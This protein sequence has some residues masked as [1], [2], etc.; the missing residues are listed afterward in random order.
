MSK[1]LIIGN[2]NS[3]WPIDHDDGSSYWADSYNFLA[4]GGYK[5]LFG[6]S[7]KALEN[8][9]VYPDKYVSAHVCMETIGQQLGTGE[10]VY[11]FYLPCIYNT[12]KFLVKNRQSRN[13]K[14]PKGL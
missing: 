3:V 9:Y 2:Y 12:S 11:C 13:I 7:K 5:N 1:C 4:Y 14:T 6:H 10:L 8:V